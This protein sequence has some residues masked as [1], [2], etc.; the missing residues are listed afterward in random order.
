MRGVR[1]N[2][3]YITLLAGA[4][5]IIHAYAAALAITCLSRDYTLAASAKVVRA[6]LALAVPLV[7]SLMIVRSAAEFSPESL[8]SRRWLIP[9]MPL[10]Y[11]REKQFSGRSIDEVVE[12]GNL[13]DPHHADHGIDN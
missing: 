11:T 4:L 1:R 13:N 12:A 9:L 2:M 8:P 3:V 10:L 5:V 6:F 7:A